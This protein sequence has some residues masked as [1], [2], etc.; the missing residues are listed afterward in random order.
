M[1][2]KSLKNSLHN[3]S[4]RLMLLSAAIYISSSLILML[5][6]YW[7]SIIYI[8]KKADDHILFDRK[9]L[10]SLYHKFGRETLTM[11]LR[12]RAMSH[13]FDSIYLLYDVQGNI[14]SGDLRRIPENIQPGWNDIS[15][16]D[17]RCDNMPHSNHAR[18]L[19]RELDDGL[20]LINGLDVKSIRAQEQLLLQIMGFGLVI[21]VLLGVLGGMVV[22][23]NA[24]RRIKQMNQTILQIKEGNLNLRLAHG[25]SNTDHDLL[26]RNINTML[27]QIY[28]LITDLENIS[29]HI[30]HDLRTP[31][32]R[33]RG[34]LEQLLAHAD[35]RQS[36]IVLEAIEE[37]NNLL[38]AFNAILRISK[39]ESGAI[40]TNF[41][42]IP[43]YQLVDDVIN[44]YEPLASERQIRIQRYYDYQGKVQADRD[45]LFQAIANI[46]DNAIKYAPKESCLE[47][48]IKP[49]SA[50]QVEHTEQ[51]SIELTIADKGTG[52]PVQERENVFK[53][54]YQLSRHRDKRGH[55]LGL[56]LVMAIIKLHQGT[57]ELLDNQPGLIVKIIL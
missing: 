18:V 56:S 33:M 51:Q 37:A 46:V 36:T 12:E 35:Q 10:V 28:V 53:R 26:A 41:S 3:S 52:I 45:M 13:T 50:R 38:S 40:K 23:R 6:I 22:S 14:Y 25:N 34:K 30:S 7:F 55:G 44:F 5:L 48:A 15:L 19:N 43:L 47:I 54:F 16:K 39:V 49:H 29:N 17:C 24:M 31:L 21:I 8:Q 20:Y 4:V 1:F 9:T 11:A 32:T 42:P 27:D 57:I 2:L